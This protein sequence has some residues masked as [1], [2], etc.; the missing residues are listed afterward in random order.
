MKRR[1]RRCTLCYRDAVRK[2]IVLLLFLVACKQ[3]AEIE[4][5]AK[6]TLDATRAK[7]VLKVQVRLDQQ[8][9]PTPDEMATRR[10]IED[11][12]QQ[13]NVGTLTLSTTDIGHYDMTIE[14]QSTNDAIPRVRAI[15][16]E[17][18]VGER[19][20]VKVGTK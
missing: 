6:E 15:L 7:E 9:A 13:E 5:V 19:A 16:R 1:R 18:G 12:I 14:V 4:Q 8:V 17:A 20:T 2:W 10:Q 3:S 11:R